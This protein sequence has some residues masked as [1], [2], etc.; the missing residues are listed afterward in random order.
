VTA[1]PN[2]RSLWTPTSRFTA[3]SEH[4]HGRAVNEPSAVAFDDSSGEVRAVGKEAK[5]M[6]GRTP[7]KI[8][9]IQPLRDGVIADLGSQREC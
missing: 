3:P 9:V 5:E 4:G 2:I 7:S 8:S 1:E 6:L